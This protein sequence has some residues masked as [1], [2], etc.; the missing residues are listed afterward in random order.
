[1]GRVLGFWCFGYLHA[2]LIL[3][4]LSFKLPSVECRTYEPFLSI[5]GS[6]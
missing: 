4:I 3:W 2:L 1:M 5:I 6:Q